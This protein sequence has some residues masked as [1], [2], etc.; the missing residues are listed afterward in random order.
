MTSPLFPSEYSPRLRNRQLN[1][2]LLPLNSGSRSNMNRAIKK[3][4]QKEDISIFYARQSEGL[5]RIP[6][7]LSNSIYA[8][9]V[10]EQFNLFSKINEQVTS[11]EPTSIDIRK[12][13]IRQI[14]DDR[15]SLPLYEGLSTSNTRKKLPSAKEHTA[16]SALVNQ[17]NYN[18]SLAI[19]D[20]RLPTAWDMRVRHE[21]IEA[22]PDNLQLTYTGDGKDDSDVA[23]VR[24]NHA[25]RKQCGI[26]YFE[27]RVISKG[28][29]GHIGIGFCR[30]INS[31]NR[32]P[33]WGEHSWGYHG[34][35]G[36][37]YAGPGTEKTYGPKY[38]TGDIIGCGIDFRD[39]SA[40]YTKNG[41]Y[42]GTAFGNVK[43]TDIYP[44][45]GFKTHKEQIE[46][47]FGLS[48]FKFDIQQYM[49][50]EKREAVNSIVN[51]PTQKTTPRSSVISNSTCKNNADNLI[52]EY[53]RHSGYHKS[54]I[55]LENTMKLESEQV[56]SISQLDSETVHRQGN[57]NLLFTIYVY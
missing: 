27:I 33:G 25:I 34:E 47:N 48:P 14:L 8:H 19:L 5:P 32:F 4:N 3:R 26:Y 37:I 51:Q 22:S 31:L 11:A 40:F 12:D 10:R 15:I 20:L 1:S 36:N 53:L 54:A 46:A 56:D 45:V 6:S 28:M 18:L 38:G 39:M 49:T 7:Y 50:N 30:K 52:M 43:D 17:S 21:F 35:N 29:D 44:F 42:L 13:K 2:S 23:S 57:T 16:L 41:L 9:L 24:A 55:A